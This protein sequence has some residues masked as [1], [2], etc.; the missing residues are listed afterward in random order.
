MH[1]Q[2]HAYISPCKWVLNEKYSND[3]SVDRYKPRVVAKGFNQCPGYDY[4]DVFAPTMSILC[5]SCLCHLCNPISM[6]FTNGDLDETILM[7]QPECSHDGNPN[8][9]LHLLKSIYGLK[10]AARMWNKKP[11]AVLLELEF[12]HLESEH[13]MYVKLATLATSFLSGPMISP[14]H[15]TPNLQFWMWCRSSP[16]ISNYMT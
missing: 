9:V 14:L 3:G 7:Q 1:L 5:S 13:S 12:V 8:H 4:T 16:N 10:Q 15:P 11:H 6:A 2:E